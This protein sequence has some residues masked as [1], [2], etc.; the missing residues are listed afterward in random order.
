MILLD[1]HSLIWLRQGSDHLGEKARQTIDEAYQDNN[2]AVSAISFWE[3]G[4]LHAKRRIRLGVDLRA[5]RQRLCEQGLIEIAID[6]SIGLEAAALHDFHGDPADRLIVSTALL[7][8]CS[9]VTADQR[10]L[11]WT[12]DVARVNASL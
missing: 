12:G 11:A 1:T 8:Q 6:G 5:W 2:L 3:V 9:L 10:I 4:M 7:R